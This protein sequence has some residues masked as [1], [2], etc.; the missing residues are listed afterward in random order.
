M[1][2][3]VNGCA[4]QTAELLNVELRVPLT[5]HD[6]LKEVNFGVLEGTPFLELYKKKHRTLNFDWRPSGESLDQV[7]ERLLKILKQIKKERAD[8][9]ALIVSHGGII[10]LMQFFEFGQPL[11]DIANAS[12]HGFD[13]DK[14]LAG[15]V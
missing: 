14:V 13:L 10:R 7:K 3:L 1:C 9:E 15:H 5:L 4:K 8:G 12:L 11:E 6:E 2:C